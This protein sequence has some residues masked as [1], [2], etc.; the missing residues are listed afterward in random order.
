MACHLLAKALWRSEMLVSCELT[1]FLKELVWLL[2]N[3]LLALGPKVEARQ[4][5]SLLCCWTR[6]LAFML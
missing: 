3:E 2:I 4:W 5:M 6:V 1:L